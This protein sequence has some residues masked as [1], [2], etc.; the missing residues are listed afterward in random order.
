MVVLTTP[1]SLSQAVN[2]VKTNKRGRPD[3]NPKK[4]KPKHF[5]FLYVK[6][7]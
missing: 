7:F 5:Y 4:I 3:E 2:V 1:S 6:K